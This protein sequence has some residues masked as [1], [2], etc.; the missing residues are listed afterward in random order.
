MLKTYYVLDASIAITADRAAS[1]LGEPCMFN[2]LTHLLVN[3]YLVVPDI[4]KEEICGEDNKKCRSRECIEFCRLLE[5]NTLVVNG[6]NV[7]L[8]MIEYGV[9]IG[10]AAALSIALELESGAT[11]MEEL[12]VLTSDGDAR[13]AAR[14]LNLRAH[15]DLYVIELAKLLKYCSSQ[16]AAN[17]AY[18]LP[19]LGRYISQVSIA[20]AV[21][22][23]KSQKRSI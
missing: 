17:L 16:E 5:N 2:V 3:G 1:L 21:Q 7:R 9:D 11:S 20:R 4:V 10:E 18:L 15:G 8:L 19:S 6:S 14:A 23:L 13:K 22:I 12:I